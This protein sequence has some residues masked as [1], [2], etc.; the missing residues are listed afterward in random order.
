MRTLLSRDL[1]RERCLARDGY[2]CVIC[3][4]AENLSVHHIIERRLFDDYGYYMDNGATLCEKCH[5][6]AEKTDLSCEGIREAAGIKDIILPDSYYSDHRYT[7]WGDII[8]NNGQRMKGP[9]FN[10]DSVQKIIKQSQSF[11]LYTDYVK[12]PR[13]YHLPWSEGKTDDDKTLADCKHFEGKEVIILEKMD[14]ENAT[15]YKN[16]YHARSIDGRDHWSRSYAKN[17]QAKIGFEIPDGWRFAGENLYAKHSIS[18]D[19]LEDYVLFF[20]IWNEKNVCLSW[21]ETI[22]YFDI[23]GLHYPKIFYRGIWDEKYT[24]NLYKNFDRSRV[25]G[26]VVRLAGS[27]SYAAFSKSVAKFVRAEH[28]A[29]SH[30]WMFTARDKNKLKNST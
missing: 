13:T 30:H 10:D 23:L 25:E 28:V 18:Y 21:D 14:G 5:I 20:S 26:Y 6:E 16:G 15:F 12:Y 24:Q 8:L 17:L 19:D 4:A 11:G 2:K 29:T 1:F 22:A 9:L 7:K 3:G 27:F